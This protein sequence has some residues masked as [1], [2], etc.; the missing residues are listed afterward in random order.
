M[1]IEATALAQAMSVVMNGHKTEECG[2]AL[3]ILI[4]SFINAAG[5][6]L[7]DR[8]RNEGIDAICSDAKR[9]SALMAQLSQHKGPVQ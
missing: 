4:A 2:I 9:T 6:N 8:E 1:S 7:T 3:G 5:P